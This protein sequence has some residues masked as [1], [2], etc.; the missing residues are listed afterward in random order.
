MRNDQKS[1]DLSDKYGKCIKCKDTILFNG[2][3]YGNLKN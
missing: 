2:K 3:C 1:C